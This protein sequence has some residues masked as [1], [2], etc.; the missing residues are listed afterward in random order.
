MA[1]FYNLAILIDD[2]KV[3]RFFSK[4]MLLKSGISNKVIVFEDNLKAL[5]FINDIDHE[6]PDVIFT[7][8]NSPL[9]NGIEFLEALK[10]ISKIFPTE[11]VVLKNKELLPEEKKQIS[12]FSFV[13]AVLHKNLKEYYPKDILKHLEKAKND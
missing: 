3:T 5:S 8:L 1:S 4:L 11:V 12:S 7:S 13:K 2:D 9:M 10:K 6:K